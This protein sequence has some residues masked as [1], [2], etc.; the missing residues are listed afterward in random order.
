MK[1]DGNEKPM[2]AS[3]TMTRSI[4]L[5]RLRAAMMPPRTPTI[6]HSTNADKAIEPVIGNVSLTMSVTDLF[7]STE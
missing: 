6:I 4:H 7:C 3:A 2:S 1:K 5:P